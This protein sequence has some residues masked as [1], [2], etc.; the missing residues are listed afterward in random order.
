MLCRTSKGLVKRKRQGTQRRR[1]DK[2]ADRESG[3]SSDS[4]AEPT[5]QK[6]RPDKRQIISQPDTD[7]TTINKED[8]VPTASKNL[9]T[10]ILL[11]ENLLATGLGVLTMPRNLSPTI[12]HL[13]ANTDLDMPA[14]VRS[15]LSTAPKHCRYN[16]RRGRRK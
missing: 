14:I 11:I 8:I 3:S 16:T 2:L 1:V 7:K 5:D 4:D 9:G 6:V 15:K 13:R 10:D 12:A